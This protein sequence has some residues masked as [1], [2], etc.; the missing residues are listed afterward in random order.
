MVGKRHRAEAK[1][2]CSPVLSFSLG[3]GRCVVPVLSRRPQDDGEAWAQSDLHCAL[4]VAFH[5]LSWSLPQGLCTG[6]PLALS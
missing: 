6:S 1:L 3:A 4:L 5:L 2:L